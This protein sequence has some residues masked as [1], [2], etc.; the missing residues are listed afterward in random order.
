MHSVTKRIG[1]ILKGEGGAA[2]TLQTLL[3][4]ILV[5]GINVATGVITARALGPQGRGEQA[6]MILWSVFLPNLL[7]VGAPSALIYNFRRFPEK[8]SEFFSAAMLVGIVMG[9]VAAVLGI[10][11]MPIWL[12]KYSPEII[13]FAQWFMLLSP[14]VLIQLIILA[15]LEAIG[16]FSASN[17][18][19]L[20]IPLIT[21]I[22]L[23]GLGLTNALTPFTSALAYVINGLPIFF[24]TLARLWRILKPRWNH[25]SQSCKQLLSYGLRSY[26][27][28]LLGALSLQVD[29]VLVVGF[30]EPA[31]M[32][33]YV[34]VLSLSR[35]L[36]VFQT[37]IVSV[38]FPKAAA[39][40]VNEVLELTGRSARITTALTLI[41]GLG[42]IL[43]GAPLLN[44]LYGAEF[45]SATNVLYIL[46]IEVVLAGTTLV[47]AQSFMALGRPGIVTVLQGVGLGLSVPLMFLL[48]PKFGIVG[49]G[50]SLLGSTIARLGFILICFPIVLKVAPP[51]LLITLDEIKFLKNRFL[52]I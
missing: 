37:S 33:T 39:R 8:K 49:A 29:Q 44:L 17:R 32:G 18:L 51:S 22:A 40:P 4:R 20:L 43:L 13:R 5:L 23:I 10:V 42:I 34:V 2:A 30:L 11:C 12:S 46:V 24:W 47:L 3:S 48:I 36:N 45:V 50:L 15:A 31:A 28:D 7:T 9:A 1:W 26:G 14:V 25:I 52:R 6:A 38:L 21:L 16:E 27:V 35:M 41:V 19:R